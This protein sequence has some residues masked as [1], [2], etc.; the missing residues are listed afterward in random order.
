MYKYISIDENM[1]QF[2]EE[3]N[4][5]FNFLLIIIIII[6]T[7]LYFYYIEEKC[8]LPLQDLKIRE[9][10]SYIIFLLFFKTR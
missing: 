5:F 4:F 9:A 8:S 3:L 10:L 7:F 1:L 2:M 6:I